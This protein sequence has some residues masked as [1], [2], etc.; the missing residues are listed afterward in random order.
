MT[1]ASQLSLGQEGSVHQVITATY[2]N[3]VLKPEPALLLHDQQQVLLVIVPVGASASTHQP[4]PMR[5]ASMQKQV[6]AWL[7]MQP[8]DAI[9]LPLPEMEQ[10]TL[11]QE[12][13][14]ASE[15][16]EDQLLA[17]IEAALAEVRTLSTE[18]AA[19]L[20][21]ELNAILAGQWT[22]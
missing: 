12:V 22:H 17:D 11:M 18:E 21:A 1:F 3:G 4:D 6:E 9:R 10:T 14:A 2:E 19:A 13:A 5:V 16:D 8:A 20:D 15:V 7:K